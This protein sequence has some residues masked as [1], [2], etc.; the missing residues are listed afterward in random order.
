MNKY[1][2][3]FPLIVLAMVCG[4][5]P[6]A[7]AQQ[8][9]NAG[10]SASNPW[11]PTRK[12]PEIVVAKISTDGTSIDLLVPKTVCDIEDVEQLYTVTVPVEVDG[13]QKLTTETRS[14][15][16]R[17]QRCKI[18]TERK[19]LMLDDAKFYAL[20]GTEFSIE[21]IGSQLKK[22]QHVLFGQLPDEYAKSVLRH[23][24]I[25]IVENASRTG[26]SQ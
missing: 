7:L 22:P 26:N 24:L 14:K 21:Q 20:D 10:S 15:T 8:G 9:A 25:C 13:K 6:I 12:M 3:Q 16:V 4:I 19:K 23:D 18:E 17:I 11:K 5:A 1:F 2:W